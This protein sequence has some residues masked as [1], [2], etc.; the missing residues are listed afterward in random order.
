MST[1][2]AETKDLQTQ[3]AFEMRRYTI[4]SYFQW[5]RDA[6]VVVMAAVVIFTYMTVPSNHC[7]SDSHEPTVTTVG[8]IPTCC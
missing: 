5:I 8:H 2:Q 4:M 6:V 3:D 1:L 7:D